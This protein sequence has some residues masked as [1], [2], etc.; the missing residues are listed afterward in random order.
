[1]KIIELKAENIKKLV[2]VEIRPDGNLV[3]ITGKN[4]QGKTSVLDCLWWALA[5]AGN[6]Q[7]SPIRKGAES[8]RIRLDLWAI[9]VTR[10][11]KPGK[12]VGTTSSLIVENAEGA[13][14]PSPQAMLDALLGTLA[15]DP[16]AFARMS[17][18]EQFDAMRGFVPGVDFDAL[19]QMNQLDYTARTDANRKAKE[20]RAAAG[21]IAIPENPSSGLVD[22]SAITKE[23]EA[24][25]KH[26]ADIETRKANREQIQREADQK[27][28][29]GVRLR[30]RAANLREEA[31]AM[32]REASTRLQE[33]AEIEKKIDPAPPL[34]SKIDTT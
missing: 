17:P 26:N 1:M 9:V 19:D 30:E 34:P 28:G 6:I 24:A 3:Q 33:A 14:F 4:G 31:D 23:L 11:F 2:A 22:I 32:D 15:F 27:K 21:K 13:R 8:A 12:D 20:E 29:E 7:A 25:G 16:L 5:G 18:K 10:T